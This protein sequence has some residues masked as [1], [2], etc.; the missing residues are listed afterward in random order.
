M[1][2]IFLIKVIC[3]RTDDCGYMIKTQ[4]AYE[5]NLRCPMCNN[6][7]SIEKSVVDESVKFGI[8]NG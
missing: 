5:Y 8:E 6:K 4:G 3:N 1:G 7:I 2:A